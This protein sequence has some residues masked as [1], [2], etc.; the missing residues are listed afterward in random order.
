M[1]IMMVTTVNVGFVSCDD[2]DDNNLSGGAPS[3]SAGVIDPNSGLRIK[4]FENFNV[5]YT[6]DGKIDYIIN[7]SP[8]AKYEFS[9]N[10]NRIC[11]VSSVYSESGTYIMSYNA[12]GWISTI[13]FTDD[14]SISDKDKTRCTGKYVF[15]YDGD[16]HLTS[17]SCYG[18]DSISSDGTSRIE[19]FSN[20]TTYTWGD[21]L[22]KEITNVEKLYGKEDIYTVAY[23]YATEYTNKYKQWAGYFRSKGDL[24]FILSN[25]GLM[26]NGPDKLPSSSSESY[27]QN[28]SYSVTYSYRFNNDG[29]V[30]YASGCT[31]IYETTDG[32]STTHVE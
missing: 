10:P 28:D 8:K 20:N 24:L 14:F 17:I 12:N 6:D 26:G 18:K 21:G 13:D 4:S 30:S 11:Y 29:S 25:L 27:N 9:Y 16:G 32:A 19:N 15:S 23:S 1:T 2:D 3:T 5:Y 31:F 7:S 22:L